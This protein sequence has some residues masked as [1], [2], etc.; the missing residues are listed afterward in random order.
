MPDSSSIS[1]TFS[2]HFDNNTDF[3]L[4]RTMML[5]FETSQKKISGG[6]IIKHNAPKDGKA[7]VPDY[8]DKAFPH[9]KN[10]RYSNGFV[11]FSKYF[12]N[13]SVCNFR[14]D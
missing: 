3:Q 9:V 2:I 5:E 10:E 12:Q 7:D 6:A 4:C 8:I 11:S 1:V 13:D 14:V